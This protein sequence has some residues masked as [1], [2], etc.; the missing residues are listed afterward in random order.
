MKVCSKCKR[1]LPDTEFYKSKQTKRGLSCWCKEC[2]RK[3]AK[4]KSAE[5]VK[6]HSYNMKKKYYSFV[7]SLKTPCAKC[8]NTVPYVLDFHHID[9]STKLFELT[10]QYQTKQAATE[11]AKKCVCLCRNCHQT[12]HHFYGQKP[13]Q[14]I[15]AL[16]E[17][18]LDEWTPPIT[19]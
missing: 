17:F 19:N 7:D 1:T 15:E 14:P 16:N 5:A 12:F 2:S 10:R 8:G 6:E 4:K 11:E 13:K 9:P 18:L 3:S